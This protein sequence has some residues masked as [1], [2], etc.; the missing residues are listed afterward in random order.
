MKAIYLL[1]GKSYDLIYGQEERAKLASV[2]DFVSQPLDAEKLL[3]L[4]GD[5]FSDVEVIVSGWGMPRLDAALLAR[6]PKL[7][8]VLYGAGSIKG[9][10]TPEMWARGIRVVSAWA[11][12]AVPVAEF[13]FAEIIFS[14]KHGWR[15]ATEYKSGRGGIRKDVPPPGAYKSTVGLISL[16]MIGKMIVEKLKQLEL[17]VIAFDP[18]V[19]T[20]DG[21]AIGVEIMELSE[22]FRKADVVSCHTPWLKETEKMLRK[23]HFESM[24]SGA[25]FINTAR[26]AVID[27]NGMIEALRS[28][29]D[30]YA[31]LDVTYPEPPVAESP[32]YDLPNVIL[33]PHIA[34]SMGSECQRMGNLVIEEFKRYLAGEK[35]RY[36]IS[37]AMAEK[38]A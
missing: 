11:A 14:L 36:E 15:F 5:A 19:S 2:L 20:T 18:Y 6:F 34:G 22:V 9:F 37:Q 7:K 21:E 31:V 28:R 3:K 27:E 26:G 13:A 35:L 25:T 1:N 33:T 24:K 29:P 30:I 4:S 32:L 23:E 16:G 38:L 10:A 8:L 17:R 12:N